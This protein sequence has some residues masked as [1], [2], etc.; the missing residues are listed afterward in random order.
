MGPILNSLTA[1]SSRVA[2]FENVTQALTALPSALNNQV[3]TFESMSNS[4]SN[5]LEEIRAR[6]RINHEDNDS[7]DE[8]FVVD[9]VTNP[10]QALVQSDI[11]TG[12]RLPCIK[13]LKF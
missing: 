6:P 12:T 5:V 11:N 1:L 8:E 13:L 4:I 2:Q 10:F 3:K 9:D 7:Q